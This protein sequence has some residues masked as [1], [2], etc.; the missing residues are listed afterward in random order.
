[1]Q[2]VIAEL[3]SVFKPYRL[4]DDFSGCSHCVSERE[5]RE[6]AA[7]RL[8]DLQAADLNRYSFKAMTTWGTVRDFKHFLPRLLELAAEDLLQLEFP[9][10]LFGKLTYGKWHSWTR[11]EREVVQSFFDA[12]WLQQFNRPFHFP[13]DERV[14]IALDCLAQVCDSLQPFL[15]VWPAQQSESAA[16]HLAQLITHGGYEVLTTGTFPLWAQPKPHGLEIA[17]WLATAAPQQIQQPYAAR[18]EHFF[19][20]VAWQLEGIRAAVLAQRQT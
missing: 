3:Y 11:R 2:A 16:Y 13:G 10:T 15:D 19:P 1:M 4:G 17:Q 18:I 8:R 7:I 14:T 6:L 20:D 9:E 5:S 12:F